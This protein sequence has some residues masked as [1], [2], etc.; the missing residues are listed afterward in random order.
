MWLY[1]AGQLANVNHWVDISDTIEQ[2]IQALESHTSQIG[3]WASSGGLRQ[4]ILKWA[5]ETATRHNLGYKYTE[6]FQRIVL[7]RDEERPTSALPSRNRLDLA[8]LNPRLGV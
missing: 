6:G 1:F 8:A 7:I 3:D 5:A 4:E 2:K